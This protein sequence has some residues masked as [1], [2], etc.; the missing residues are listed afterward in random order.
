MNELTI[1]GLEDAINQE[2]YIWGGHANEI[3]Y[4]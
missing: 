3:R 1:M 2:N 4:T